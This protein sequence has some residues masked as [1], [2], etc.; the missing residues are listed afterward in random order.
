MNHS[1]ADSRS[2]RYTRKN[3]PGQVTSWLWFV[4]CV[5]ITLMYESFFIFRS[6][7]LNIAESLRGC[8]K[9]HLTSRPRLLSTFAQFKSLFTSRP[10]SCFLSVQLCL[11][12][13]IN[14]CSF[15]RGILTEAQQP[16]NRE[17]LFLFSGVQVW[18]YSCHNK[19]HVRPCLALPLL[20]ALVRI[21]PG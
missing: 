13:N 4:G 17:I 3:A 7:S 2:R 9:N 19:L 11:L 10:G 5:L 18:L 21:S 12:P 15:S 8:G 16:G 1:N 14:F 6:I 20:S